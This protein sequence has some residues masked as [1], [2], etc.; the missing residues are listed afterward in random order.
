MS[1]LPVWG[2]PHPGKPP[3]LNP[4]GYA[5]LRGLKTALKLPMDAMMPSFATLRDYGNTSCSSTWYVMAYMESLRGVE[6]GQTIMQLGIGGG[7]KTGVNVWRALKSNRS[8]HG[9]WLHRAGVPMR[10]EDLPRRVEEDTAP[11]QATDQAPGE[12]HPE[13][14]LLEVKAA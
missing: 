5:V 1:F 11:Q 12:V 13:Q 8:P 7:M 10:P 14:E 4:G 9:A 3:H 6:R 2:A